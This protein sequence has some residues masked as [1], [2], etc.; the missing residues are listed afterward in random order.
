MK[1]GAGALVERGP[2]ERVFSAPS[3]PDA[4]LYL[5]GARG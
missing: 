5:S 2:A 1:D 4:A 3:D